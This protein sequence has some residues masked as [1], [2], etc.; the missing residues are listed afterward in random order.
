MPTNYSLIENV[1]VNKIAKADYDLYVATGIITA[2]MIANEVWIFTDDNFLSAENLAKLE[3]FLPT[4]YY[5]RAEVYSKTEVQSLMSALNTLK[6][7]IVDALPTENIDAK[8]VY[9]T[10]K[11]DSES[12]N[13]YDENIYINGAWEVIGDTTIDL[14][15]YYKKSEADAKFMTDYTETDPTVPAW[16]KAAT[17]PSYSASEVG[18][19]PANTSIPTKLSD[20][21]ADANHRTV[22]DAEKETWNGKAETRIWNPAE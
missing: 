20:L 16:A 4:D 3:A 21:S 10:A 11:A 17:K 12:G 13:A 7:Q 1:K 5:K 6:F 15:D 19:L 8:T 22:T 14:S 2:E 9:L 18:A